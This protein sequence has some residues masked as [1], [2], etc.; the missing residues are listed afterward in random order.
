MVS[1]FVEI[2]TIQ[3]YIRFIFSF[4]QGVKS[5]TITKNILEYSKNSHVTAVQL[6]L[7]FTVNKQ[8][9]LVDPDTSF[10]FPFLLLLIYIVSDMFKEIS[11]MS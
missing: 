7:D 9:I 6:Q 10:L 3:L 4:L 8:M 2:F 11:A 1:I 5:L